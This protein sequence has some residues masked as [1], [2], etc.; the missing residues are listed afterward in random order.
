MINREIQQWKISKIKLSHFFLGG[1]KMKKII[2]I[3]QRSVYSLMKKM[4]KEKLKKNQ[5][6]KEMV[7][8]EF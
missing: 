2:M 3:E 6:H 5:F 8:S 7:E 1:K 4:K